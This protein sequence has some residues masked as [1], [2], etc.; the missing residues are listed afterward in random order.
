[1]QAAEEEEAAE[2]LLLQQQQQQHVQ[3]P[4]GVRGSGAFQPWRGPAA[5]NGQE[6]SPGPS[7]RDSKSVAFDLKP[8]VRLT[9]VSDRFIL[10]VLCH[11]VACLLQRQFVDV[12]TSS[13]CAVSVTCLAPYQRATTTSAVVHVSDRCG[14]WLM[15]Q[16]F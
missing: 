14:T 4:R 10:L 2:Q 15:C 8:R 7:Q 5:D 12:S 6:A 3:R 11:H 13:E 1:M 16:R 9:F